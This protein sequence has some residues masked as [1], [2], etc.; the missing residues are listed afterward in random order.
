MEIN[1][2]HT[3]EQ[4]GDKVGCNMECNTIIKELETGRCIDG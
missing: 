3:L 1:L 4:N 2:S